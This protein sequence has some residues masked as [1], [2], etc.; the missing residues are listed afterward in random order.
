MHMTESRPPEGILWRDRL[1]L[2]VALDPL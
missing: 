1:R 2:G